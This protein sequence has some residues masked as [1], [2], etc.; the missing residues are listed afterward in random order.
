MGVRS[1]GALRGAYTGLSSVDSRRSSASPC[2]ASTAL[3]APGETAVSS[4]AGEPIAVLLR[5]M[6]TYLVLAAAHDK[7]ATLNCLELQ[8]GCPRWWWWWLPAA[9]REVL[10][11]CEQCPT[12]GGV[13]SNCFLGRKAVYLT[14]TS[15]ALSPF[16]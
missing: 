5:N 4:S 7:A 9:P 14:C 3:A 1:Q 8:A 15:L 6:W 10:R 12:L 2:S 11:H 16:S 13:S